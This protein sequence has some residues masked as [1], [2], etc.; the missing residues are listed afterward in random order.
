VSGPTPPSTNVLQGDDG[1]ERIYLLEADEEMEY[2]ESISKYSG[3]II[4]KVK[5]MD[6]KL[7]FDRTTTYTEVSLMP[8]ALEEA[9]DNGLGRISKSRAP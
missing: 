7:G 6:K 9:A 5:S 3:V 2:Q 1:R 8:N 4:R